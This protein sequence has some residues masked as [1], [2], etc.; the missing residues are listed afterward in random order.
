[1]KYKILRVFT[2]F[3]LVSL[4]AQEKAATTIKTTAVSV[5]T[6][7]V[8]D[9]ANTITQEDLKKLV[10]TLASDKYEGRKTGKN[11]QK[12]AAQYLKNYYMERDIAGA[13]KG[14]RFLQSIPRSYFRGRSKDS[15][16]NV[17]AFIKGTSKPEEYIVLS[18]HYDH[19][20]VRGG[21]IYNGADD[22][23]SGTSA[24]LEIAEAFKKAADA[25]NGPKR[26]L[27]FLHVSGEEIGLFGSKYYTENPVFSLE[28]TV[29]NL[30]IDMIGRVDDA[31]K[32]NPD[33]VYLIG[34]DKISQELH[35][36]SEA[37]NKKYINLTLDYTYNDKDDP[38]RFYYRSDHYNFAKN[39]IP[40]IF[41][42]N[43]VH[44]DY[45]KPTDTP[46]KIRYDLLQKR[47]QLIFYT[48][49]ELANRQN[50]LKIDK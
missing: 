22:D 50:R 13:Q 11:G 47:T 33:F 10:Y 7:S 15:A 3:L 18:A 42:F 46:D 34:S 44:K 27:V 20:G 16:S 36:V 29:A 32:N 48:A 24:V 45:H 17:I 23:A 39:G 12:L 14:N 4:Q 49:W 5:K 41:Y 2:C 40:I 38:N 9:Y 19:V 6:S 43:G 21:K 8:I 26:S 25:G 31:H 28:N 30:N 1:M 37:V 35:D